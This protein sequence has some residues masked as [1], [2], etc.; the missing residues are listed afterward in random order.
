MHI[1]SLDASYAQLELPWRPIG[2]PYMHIFHL[3]FN[4]FW[5]VLAVLAPAET[6]PFQ[7]L[8]D[9]LASSY[10]TIMLYI[11]MTD[12]LCACFELNCNS[13][14]RFSP[15][16]FNRFWPFAIHL[17]DTYIWDPVGLQGSPSCAHGASRLYICITGALCP[18]CVWNW[19]SRALQDHFRDNDPVPWDE[20]Y[21]KKKNSS[22]ELNQAK[23]SHR[24][25]KLSI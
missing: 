11:C 15:I 23:Q 14:D 5:P 19:T 20:T 25:S 13:R 2:T 1:Y 17:E 10:C 24:A 3:Y 8:A 21:V 18:Y 7:C 9:V 22:V 16:Y 12:I 6:V 4:R